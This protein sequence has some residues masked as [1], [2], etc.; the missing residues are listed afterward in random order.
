MLYEVLCMNDCWHR[1]WDNAKTLWMSNMLVV[2]ERG[3]SAEVFNFISQRV[4]RVGGTWL[5]RSLFV[6]T[7]ARGGGGVVKH[8]LVGSNVAYWARNMRQAIDMCEEVCM[9]ITWW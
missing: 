9:I 3:W 5:P 2:A 4:W 1:A 7:V 8:W 6:G